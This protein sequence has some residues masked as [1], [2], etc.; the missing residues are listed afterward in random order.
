MS[1]PAVHEWWACFT[2]AIEASLL[3][4]CGETPP[5]AGRRSRMYKKSLDLPTDEEV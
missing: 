3:Q 5:I 1:V 4:E 2:T